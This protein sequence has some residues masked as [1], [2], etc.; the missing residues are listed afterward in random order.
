MKSEKIKITAKNLKYGDII[1]DKRSG[2]PVEVTNIIWERNI[3]ILFLWRGDVLRC[4][5]CERHVLV[6][7]R[8]DDEKEF[9]DLLSELEICLESCLK[10]TN[11]TRM[12]REASST[13]ELSIPNTLMVSGLLGLQKAID[14]CFGDH[15]E[16]LR[17]GIHAMSHSAKSK[18][19]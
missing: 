15:P 1:L 18:K 17:K 9:S 2:L 6:F 7:R 5:P 10:V 4:H 3:I 14:K 11:G 16:T 19:R 8:P 13:G 12:M